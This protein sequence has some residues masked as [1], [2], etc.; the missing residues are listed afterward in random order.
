VSTYQRGVV[1]RVTFEIEYPDG[2][3]KT[4]ELEDSEGLVL[5]AFDESHVEA[6]DLPSFNVS[7]TEW[8]QNPAMVVYKRGAISAEAA[9]TPKGIPFCTHNG[10]KQ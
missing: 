4:A 10:C 7:D 9:A 3:S 1:K 5:I 6:E 8:K 2:S